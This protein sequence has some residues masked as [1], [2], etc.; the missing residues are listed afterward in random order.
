MPQRRVMTEFEVFEE[1]ERGASP[2][3]LHYVVRNAR[4]PSL[5]GYVRSITEFTAVSSR[6]CCRST[7]RQGLASTLLKAT[8]V[9]NARNCGSS[10]GGGRTVGALALSELPWAAATWSSMGRGC[11]MHGEDV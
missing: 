9:A 8:S 5:C 7:W 11:E 10:S 3:R 1:T 4:G 2:G 6:L